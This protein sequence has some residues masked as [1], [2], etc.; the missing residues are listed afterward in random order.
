MKPVMAVLG[1]TTV[2]VVYSCGETQECDLRTVDRWATPSE[3]AKIVGVWNA[4]P[5]GRMAK[6]PKHGRKCPG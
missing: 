3:V 4:R 6:C 2:K 5:G 1:G